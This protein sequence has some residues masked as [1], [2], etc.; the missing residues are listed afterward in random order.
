MTDT[1]AKRLQ[2]ESRTERSCFTKVQAFRVFFYK[3]IIAFT[4]RNAE[5]YCYS[6]I[7][8]FAYWIYGFRNFVEIRRSWNTES[9]L[10]PYAV[11]WI[12]FDCKIWR[13]RSVL[14]SLES[15]LV[16]YWKMI[17]SLPTTTNIDIDNEQI[18]GPE[19]EKLLGSILLPSYRVT[20]CKPEDKVNRKFAFKAEHANMRTYH[21]AADSRESMN[22]WVNA[23]TLAT[24][25]QDP[26]PWVSTFSSFTAIQLYSLRI[27]GERRK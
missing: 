22:Q 6:R 8:G 21:F 9:I 19:E 1:I 16:S 4:S 15:K 20:V 5:N 18:S 11:V 17:Y 10:I 7:H 12:P 2:K 13:N 26:S 14:S 27:E 3:N 24:L 25:L 23:L